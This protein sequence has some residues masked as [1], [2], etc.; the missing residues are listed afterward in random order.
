M[1]FVIKFYFNFLVFF[2]LRIKL[3]Q[4]LLFIIFIHYIFFSYFSINLIINNF[5]IIKFIKIKNILII[6]F[7]PNSNGLVWVGLKIFRLVWVEPKLLW[8]GLGWL[9]TN[10]NQL[11]PTPTL[12]P[13]HVSHYL[14]PTLLSIFEKYS[15]TPQ[16]QLLQHFYY[17]TRK[18]TY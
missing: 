10:P 4:Y 16:I 14:V 11:M 5:Y 7:K 9:K 8:F 15:C 3:L 18:T 2:N 1:I 13:Y 17:F 12:T 6:K